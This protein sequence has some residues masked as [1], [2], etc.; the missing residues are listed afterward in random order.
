MGYVEHIE[1]ERDIA[2]QNAT[3]RFEEWLGAGE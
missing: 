1:L 3:Q 2:E